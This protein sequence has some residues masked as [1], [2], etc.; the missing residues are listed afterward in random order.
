MPTIRWG[1]GRG[2]ESIDRDGVIR[3]GVAD[4]HALARTGLVSLL[5][6]NEGMSVVGEV[7]D[8]AAAFDLACDEQ[9]DVMVVDLR[10][11]DIDGFEITRRISARRPS[12]AVVVV[13]PRGGER[14]AGPAIEAGARAYVLRTT[15]PEEVLETVRM[16]ASG[17]VVLPGQA[18]L[19]FVE[20]EA[21]DRG[22]TP[23]L[24]TRELDVLRLLARGF[25]NRQ[26]A[27]TLVL[28]V[29]T[30]KT[31]VERLIRRLGAADRTEA[32]AIG[33]RSGLLE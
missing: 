17:H 22:G 28:S 21:G 5:R 9:P 13:G 24:S 31:H 8:G 6:S 12:V 30:V 10:M 16:V 14:E 23:I 4:E 33:F 25:T 11:T 1:C 27:G 20:A 19:A 3:I 18:T 29:E 15:P 26:I 7:A 2:R 32:V